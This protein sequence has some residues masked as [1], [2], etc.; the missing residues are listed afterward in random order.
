MVMVT[1]IV[2]SSLHF[3]WCYLLVFKFDMDIIGVSVATLFTYF[4]NFAVI[5]LYCMYEKEV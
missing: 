1:M 2:T 4:L 5:T 3:L